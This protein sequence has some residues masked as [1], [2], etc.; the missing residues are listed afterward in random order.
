MGA[1]LGLGRDGLARAKSQ[2]ILKVSLDVENNYSAVP[3]GNNRQT[4]PSGC[5]A[6]NTSNMTS[7]LHAPFSGFI[8]YSRPEKTQKGVNRL[9]KRLENL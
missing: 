6:R 3:C 5:S 4:T 7:F 9:G 1:S 2:N 8:T